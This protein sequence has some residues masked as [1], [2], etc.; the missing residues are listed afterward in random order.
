MRIAV[1]IA[2]FAASVVAAAPESGSFAVGALR[3]DGIVI[4]FAVYDGKRWSSRWPQPSRDEN[5]PINLNSVPGRWWGPA[6]VRESWQAAIVGEPRPLP[7]L[8]VLQPDVVDVHCTRQIGLRTDYRPADVPPPP[9]EQP[10]PKDGLAVSPPQ[11]VERVDILQPLSTELAPLREAL[12]EA[13][14]KAERETASRFN[15]PI[16]EKVRE[17]RDPEIE[18]AYA[19]GRAPRIYYIESIRVYRQIGGDDCTIAFGT[20]WL[21]RDGETIKSIVMTVDILPCD[22]YGA[23]YMLP[24]GVMR[25]NGR[26]Y[27]LAQ[28]SGWDHE[29]FVVVEIKAKQVEAVVNAWGGGC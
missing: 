24:F 3:R 29:R 11:P 14:N 6:G 15:H 25:L 27:W 22:R 5:V 26:T 2:F 21:T 12:T 18:A 23:T 9:M 16:R 19:F 17:Q 20:G 8:K 4:P 13:F 10:Y 28:Y 7:P 1:S